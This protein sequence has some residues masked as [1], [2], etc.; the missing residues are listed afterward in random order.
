MTTELSLFDEM[1]E[2][3]AKAI[4]EQKT[5]ISFKRMAG[6]RVETEMVNLRGME[7]R[8]GE[9]VNRKQKLEQVVCAK[10]SR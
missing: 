7:S 8:L 2:A 1:I 3:T 9:L 6:L 4:A 10:R 5:T